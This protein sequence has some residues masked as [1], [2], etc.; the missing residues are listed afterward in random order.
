MVATSTMDNHSGAQAKLLECSEQVILMQATYYMPLSTY[1]ASKLQA[2][3]QSWTTDLLQ[4]LP[5]TV[6]VVCASSCKNL[7]KAFRAWLENPPSDGYGNILQEVEG[8]SA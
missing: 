7:R 5:S 1:L 3:L 2:S 6:I 4:I 8:I